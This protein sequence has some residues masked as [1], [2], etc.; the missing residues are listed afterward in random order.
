MNKSATAV[1]IERDLV[2]IVGMWLLMDFHYSDAGRWLA[3]AVLFRRRITLRPSSEPN[4]AIAA[5]CSCL[6]ESKRFLPPGRKSP[7]PGCR[8]RRSWG[9]SHGSNSTL[10]FAARARRCEG[11]QSR[12][13]SDRGTAGKALQ[14]VRPR[15]RYSSSWTFQRRSRSLGREL[16]SLRIG[17]A[18]GSG[19]S[20]SSRHRRK[21][22]EPASGLT[23]RRRQA[24]R[25]SSSAQRRQVRWPSF[26]SCFG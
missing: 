12:S 1:A 26:S 20:G 8:L 17:S 21:V 18:P 14:D 7:Y 16:L 9:Y 23:P 15:V 3:V 10:T 13:E 11:P 4:P 5:D 22:W 25:P 2:V 19:S 24:H 6:R